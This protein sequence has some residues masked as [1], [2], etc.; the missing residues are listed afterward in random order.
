MKSRNINLFFVVLLATSVF[1]TGIYGPTTTTLVVGTTVNPNISNSENTS[2][3]TNVI[4]LGWDG[5]QRE[6]LF[7]LINR[8]LMPNLSAFVQTGKLF[9]VTVS[10]HY[11]DTKAGWTQILTGYRWWKTGI[12]QNSNWFHAIPRGY[13][14]PERL[15]SIFGSTQIATAFITGKLNQMEIEDRTGTAAVGS[16]FSVYSNEALYDN[17]PSQLDFVSVGDL[18]EDRY[19]NVTGPLMLQFIQNNTNN[20]FFGFFHLSDPDHI[21]HMYGEN[22]IQYENAIETCDYW[23]GQILNK[24]NTLG[25][26]QKTLIY[27][28]ADH[29][30]DEDATTHQNAPY[31]FLATNDNN[32]SRNGDQV[33]IAPTVYYGLGLWNYSFNPALDGF[34][35][36]L[37]LTETEMQHRQATLADTTSLL[38]PSIS[39]SDN[40]LGQKTV[41]FNATDNNLAAVLLLIDNRLRTDVSLTWNNTGSITASGSY[42]INTTILNQGSH[43]VKILAFDEHG[44]NNGGSDK[45]S[46]GGWP[47]INSADFY[48]GTT[49]TPSPTPY[50]TSSTLPTSSPSPTPSPKPSSSA[51]PTAISTQTPIPT[52]PTSTNPPEKGAQLSI[53][54][55]IAIGIVAAFAIIGILVFFVK[56][57][58]H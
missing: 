2:N 55:F 11:T 42:N 16:P 34:P 19:A 30:F 50:S 8:G 32:V 56:R 14:I 25:L 48:V 26:S 33:D 40:G 1:W 46:I 52:I 23:L 31:I 17:L 15:E 3:Y 54:L 24:L 35:M 36:Q 27:V 41:N 58:N 13:T 37:N 6:H 28:T 39:I 5:V 43:T 9:N 22:S 49:S 7:E 12:F 29:G 4:L 57:R 45:P 10:D 44:A 21:G 51:T 18:A 53:V 20:R 47:S 38:T